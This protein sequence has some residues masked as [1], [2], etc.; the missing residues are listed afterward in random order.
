MKQDWL[1]MYNLD[2]PNHKQ[3][4][5]YFQIRSYKRNAI[6]KSH[7]ELETHGRFLISGRIGLFKKATERLIRRRI[8]TDI[9]LYGNFFL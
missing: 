8:F 4:F 3:L 5:N 7:R 6:I 9:S 1:R 2:L